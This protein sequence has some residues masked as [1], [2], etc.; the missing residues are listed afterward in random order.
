MAYVTRKYILII[1]YHM[2]IFITVFGGEIKF[3]HASK[4]E[5][6]EFNDNCS[7]QNMTP[8]AQENYKLG[9]QLQKWNEAYRLEGNS[10]VSDEVYDQLF[11]KWQHRQRC[12][13]LPDNLPEVKVSSKSSLVRHPIPHTGLKKLNEVEVMAWVN[14]RKEVWLQPK[15]DGVAVSLVYKKGQLVS[16]ISRG[17]GIE[18][19]DWREKANFISAIPK[20]I[21]TQ[22][23]LLILQGELFWKLAS[24]IQEK[25]GGINARNKIAGWLMR[26]ASPIQIEDNIGIFVWAWPEGHSKHEVQV[27]KLAELGF[28]LAEKH[29]HK[30]ENI[31]QVKQWREHYYRSQMPFATDGIVLKSF[32]APN[33]IAWQANQNSW[34]IAWKHPLQSVVSEVKDLQFRI[35]RTGLVSVVL[36]IEPI[37]IDSK[38]VRKVSVGSFNSWKKKDL[39]VGDQIQI[40]L[41]GHG[42]P[43]IENVV[44]R[45]DKRQYPDTSE[46]EQFHFLSCLR[47]SS[48]CFQQFTAR[49]IW[50]GKQLKIKG[51]NEATWRLWVES[52]GI[53]ELTT[54]LSPDWQRKLPNTKKTTQFIKQTQEA[55]SQPLASWLKGFGIPLK[56]QQ[57]IKIKD[58]NM[59]FDHAFLKEINVSE[60]QNKKLKLWLDD[61]EIQ[62]LLQILQEIKQISH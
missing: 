49:L 31:E 36:V 12:Q 30:I 4:I 45:L 1:I 51:V 21:T 60:N 61:P 5:S 27:K 33:V 23:Q 24:H 10:L 2:S 16:V 50:L 19:I 54:W 25:Q 37:E 15:I 53:T 3:T 35:G 46:L 42:A 55:I 9:E 62:K 29:S 59:I 52:Y 44:W 56:Q 6:K 58:F 18:G 40:S 32:P 22:D 13:N 48:L 11:E 47:Y 20:T 41:A 7:T 28:N 8:F 38:I 39:L 26:K 43:K 17:N 57:I 34:A 14:T